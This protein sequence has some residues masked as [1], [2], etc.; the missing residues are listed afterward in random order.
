MS[1]DKNQMVMHQLQVKTQRLEDGLRKFVDYYENGQTS[2]ISEVYYYALGCLGGDDLK[3]KLFKTSA[4][5]SV[6]AE[7]K[8]KKFMKA[9]T[10][11]KNIAMWK[12][13]NGNIVNSDDLFAD[14]KPQV[15]DTAEK[16]SVNEV[17]E[18]PQM[19]E[20]TIV[21]VPENKEES[22]QQTP[23]QIMTFGV[24]DSEGNLVARDSVVT[25]DYADPAPCENKLGGRKTFG[26]E[27]NAEP[28]R[29]IECF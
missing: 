4:F 9:D 3:K 1:I 27:V 6:V 7:L 13:K 18:E 17:E 12:E 29:I 28:R 26:G 10:A 2:D 5:V 11:D 15:S 24:R 14:N 19:N 23:K 16:G 8:E 20:I 25:C 21:A 22:A